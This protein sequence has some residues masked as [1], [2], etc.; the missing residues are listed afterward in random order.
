MPLVTHSG[1]PASGKSTAL[2]APLRQALQARD[3]SVRLLV[4][5][6][7]LAGH[8]RN[9]LARE[10]LVLRRDTVSTLTRFLDSL[11]LADPAPSPAQL[12]SLIASLLE[13][14]C[15]AE[16]DPLR[17]RPGFHRHLAQTCEALALAAVRPSQ[18][19]GP[20][21]GLYQRVLAGLASQRLAL[22]G[23]RLEQISA[24]LTPAHLAPLR[25]LLLDGFFSFANTERTLIDRLALSI[26]V[27]LTEAHPGPS[28]PL[29]HPK[30]HFHSA[31]NAE[32]EALFI[33]G[34]I[35][36]LAQQGVELRRIGILLRNPD[37]DSPLIETTLARLAIPSRSYLGAPILQHP[38]ILLHRHLI[39]AAQNNW[40]NESVL[41]ALR[42]R[43]TGLGGSPAG[44]QLEF[45]T[46]TALPS[47]SLAAFPSLAPFAHWSH[48]LFSPSEAVAELRRVASLLAAPFALDPSLAL[49]AEWHDRSTVL[50][51][52]HQTLDQTA[53]SLPATPLPLP[54]FWSHVDSNLA[55]L[56]LHER[57]TRRN[58]VH[59][60]DFF[61]A[62]QWD[63]DYV[64]APGL[65]D[66]A[67]P[68][69]FT[70]DPLLSEAA[71]RSFGMKT[72]EDRH[73]EELFLAPILLTRAHREL[74]L[75]YPLINAKGDPLLPSP[76]LPFPPSPLP[77][78]IVAT[79]TISRPG[80]PARL[81]GPWRSPSHP[82]SASEF[83]T[84]LAC[85]FRHFASRGLKLTG[86]PESPAE[87]LNPLLL[88]NIAHEAI[89]QWTLDPSR[90][91]E[92]IADRVLDR[93]AKQARVPRGYHFERE[94]INL[95]R[96][97]K[98][99]STLAPPVPPGWTPHLEQPFTLEFPNGGPTVRGFID[100]YDRAPDGRIAAY[101]YKYSR[102]EKL[103]EKY[104]IQG[105]LYALALGEG[106]EQFSFIGLRE[107]SKP[108]TLS[109]PDLTAATTAALSSIENIL[110]LVSSGHIA[111]EPLHPQNCSW[112][113]FRDACRIRERSIPIEEPALEAAAE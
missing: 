88:G 87:R 65:F 97:L 22:R 81:S 25:L 73:N 18:V 53:A 11:A 111:V 89:R 109:G 77:P 12:Q 19:D 72:L 47:N 45:D 39:A 92:A 32:Q 101:D 79:P 15:P 33:A 56:T 27:H 78:H 44:D 75:S 68:Q 95:L 66:S 43:L 57:D 24:R 113:E 83:E 104:P 100:R 85:P 40:D 31:A 46:L 50:A 7:T 59:I 64:F 16:F 60:L 28:Q 2:L 94:R 20:L 35:L 103:D 6:A 17:A 99:Y 13:E 36:S 1:P 110:T 67:F 58:V 82:W 105:A 102:A 108:V 55:A 9:N 96:N 37:A 107:Q 63:L 80:A 54:V 69:R 49:A 26:D 23:Q 98:L 70:A 3:W 5:S 48:Q 76:L 62:R 84:F 112:C 86:L 41:A 106:V 71:K 14:R 52:L 93:E 4:P 34:H 90:D 30:V 8:L 29:R 21:S 74:H 38:V 61:E 10:G 42:T 91:I 51:T